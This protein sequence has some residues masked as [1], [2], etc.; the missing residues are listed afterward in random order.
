VKL[1]GEKFLAFDEAQILIVNNEE[2]S[3][4]AKQIVFD[5]SIFFPS[6]EPEQTHTV[7]F[8]LGT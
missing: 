1:L 7:S 4:L 8:A 2:K 5:G 6:H 3:R